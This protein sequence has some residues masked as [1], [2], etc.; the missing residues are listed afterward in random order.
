M[1]GFPSQ[2]GRRPARA[3]LSARPSRRRVKSWNRKRAD[4][5]RVAVD[6]FIE[7]V[8]TDEQDVLC[9]LLCDLMHLADREGWNFE[10]QLDR[11]RFHYGAEQTEE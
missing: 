11:A 1:S 3:A 5:A 2:Q 6:A 7:E 10:S 4:W 8:R 9:D